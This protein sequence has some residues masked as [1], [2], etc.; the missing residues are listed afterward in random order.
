MKFCTA[1]TLGGMDLARDMTQGNLAGNLIR[2]SI[3]LILSGLLQQLYN[4]ADAFIVGHVEGELALGAIGATGV[5]S[6]L[7]VTVITGFTVGLTVQTAQYYGCGERERMKDVLSTFVLVVGSLFLAAG[8]LAVWQSGN[9]LRLMDTPEDLFE[10]ALDYLR[11]VLLGVP[12]LA[13]YNVYS[14][15][16]RGM[17]DS[18][19]P[20][21][22]IIVSAVSNV[23]LDLLFVGWFRW[24]AWGAALATVLAQGLMTAFL[25]CYT[26]RRYAALR[27]WIG[28]RAVNGLELC[29]GAALGVPT[30]IQ[31]SI[32]S[33][34]G[35]ILQNFMNGFGT[36]TVTAIT[37]AYRVDLVMMLPILNLG[38]GIS[39]VA[40]QNL[41]AGDIGRARKALSVG[42]A[43]ETV[44]SLLLTV[45]MATCG[46]ALISMFGVSGEA[47]EIGRQFFRSIAGFYLAFGL[48]TALR[49]YLEGIGDLLFTS[50]ASIA[51]L[52]L[53]ILLSYGLAEPCGMMIIAYAEG[54]SWIVLVL[55]NLARYAWK[56]RS[57]VTIS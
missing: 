51:A 39:T 43:M 48:S 21:F 57:V 40:A 3:P 29:R 35:I 23:V 54:V 10:I 31:S 52:G 42:L 44:I 19:A 30:A 22:S 11:T 7:F 15:V 53:R 38:S 12:F 26:V 1:K 25:V 18:K 4:W 46:G 47:E 27:F 14:A 17:G 32:S 2:F 36:A 8:L 13:V 16:L 20:F 50:M 9:I 55:V 5:I 49:G 37:T 24:G 41:G 45:L 56:R 6:N 34:G 28:R 33:C